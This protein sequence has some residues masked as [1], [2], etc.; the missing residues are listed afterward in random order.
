MA[1]TEEQ[2]KLLQGGADRAKEQGVGDD[3]A[4]K[5]REVLTRL[6][7]SRTRPVEEAGIGGAEATYNAVARGGL[8]LRS[9]P[10][11]EQAELQAK[12]ARAEE[13]RARRDE[14]GELPLWERILTARIGGREDP[15]ALRA[16]AAKQAGIAAEVQQRK[17]N[18]PMTEAGGAQLQNIMESTSLF[19]GIKRAASDPLATM[20]GV[21]QVGLEQA[22]TIAAA[23]A[24]RNPALGIAAFSASGYVQERF[25]QLVGEAAEAGYDLTNPAQARAAIE[26]TEFMQRQEQRGKTRGVIIAAVDAITA[27][28]ASK[29][30]VSWKG[31]AGNTGVQ[32]VGGGG[33]EAAAEYADT[34]T[35]NPG[36][37]L[38][39]A[40]AEG[41]T[42]P[43]D[44]AAFALR[45]GPSPSGTELDPEA[46][47]LEAKED[48]ALQA[49]ALAE[50]EA[51]KVQAEQVEGTVREARDAYA[52]S[53]IPQAEFAKGREKQRQ[54][55]VMDPQTELGTQFRT[56]RLAENRYLTDDKTAKAH[57]AEFFKTQMPKE[58]PAVVQEEWLAALDDYATNRIELEREVDPPATQAEMALDPAQPATEGQPAPEPE[59]DADGQMALPLDEAQAAPTIA[60]AQRVASMAA[61]RGVPIAP[62]ALDVI[63]TEIEQI[64]TLESAE[65]PAAL[66]ALVAKY[67]QGKAPAAKATVSTPAAAKPTANTA[68]AKQR[69][70]AIDTLGKDWEND[71]KFPGLAPKLDSGAV[72]KKDKSGKTGFERAVDAAKNE[73]MAAAEPQA[74]ET[75]VVEG[76]TPAVENAAPATTPPVADTTPMVLPEIKDKALSPGEK[77]VW[78]VL[79]DAFQNNGQDAVI[80][81]DGT[82]NTQKIAELAGLKSRQAVR[83]ALTRL[84]PKIAKASGLKPEQIKQR[85][86]E[87]RIQN[88]EEAVAPDAPVSVLDQAGLAEGAGFN[89]KASINQGARDGMDAA[90]A[91]YLDN[92]VSNA[93]NPVADQ[94]AAEARERVRTQDE[95]MLG[96]LE[97]GLRTAW[98]NRKSD[99]GTAYADLSLEDKI[100][101]MRS[102]QEWVYSTA[103]DKD[104]TLSDDQRNLERNTIPQVENLQDENLDANAVAAETAPQDDGADAGG[105]EANRSETDTVGAADAGPVAEAETD[106]TPEVAGAAKAP[107]VEVKKKKKI[108]N[109]KDVKPRFSVAEVEAEAAGTTATAIRAATKWLIGSEQ[110]GKIIVV[111]SPEDLIGLVLGRQVPISGTDMNDILAAENPYGFVLPD[112]NGVPYAYFFT[113]NMTPGN[114][115]AAVAHEIGS[116]I[117]MDNILNEAELTKANDQILEWAEKDDG[118]LESEIAKRAIARVENAK[119]KGGILGKTKAALDAAIR[120]ENI[121]YFIEESVLAG[122]NPTVDSKLPLVRFLHRIREAFK[123]ALAKFSGN[124]NQPLFASDFIDVARGAAQLQFIKSKANAEVSPKFGVSAPTTPAEKSWVKKNFGGPK[125]VQ[126]TTDLETVAKGGR[127]STKF[128]SRLVRDVTP[129]MPSVKVWYDAMLAAEKTYNTVRAMVEGI[130]VRARQLPLERR[131]VVNKFIG[132]ATFYQKWGY[133]P[134]LEGK[135]VK[136]DPIMKQKFDR[137]SAEE[138]QVVRDVFQHGADMQKMMNDIAKEL[139]V[140]GKLFQFHSKLDGPYAPLKRFGNYVA[141]LKSQELLDAEVK[142]KE[143]G[144]KASANAVEKLKGDGAH[145]VVSFFDTAGAAA[146][147]A[148]ENETKYASAE[149][150][151]RADNGNYGTAQDSQVYNK[152]MASLGTVG[153]PSDAKTAVEK[154]LKDLYFQSLD[155]RS[156]RLAGSRRLNRAGYEKDM[157]RSVL[158]HGRSQAR[159]ISQLKH[160]AEIN[161]ALVDAQKEAKAS[162]KDRKEL[163]PIFNLV[164]RKYSSVLTPNDGFGSKLVDYTLATNTALMLSTSAGYHVQ[165]ATQPLK[166]AGKIA[167]DFNTPKAWPEVIK[168]YAV[169]RAVISSS[170][171]RQV[172]TTF[173]AGIAPTNNT[174]IIDINKA[175]PHLRPLLQK[176]QD[177]GLMDVGIE[178]DLSLGDRFD[179]G[180]ET[181]N[182]FTE[183]GRNVFHRLMQIARYVEAHNRVSSAVAAFE[184]AKKD[185]RRLKMM[186]MTAEEYAISVI[187]DTHGVY[188]KLESPV[189]VDVLPRVT[190]QFKKYPLMIAW[191]YADAAKKAFAGDTKEQK[192]AGRRVLAIQLAQTG[193]LSGAV[194]IPMFTTVASWFLAAIG[195]EDEPVDFERYI[196]DMFPDNPDMAT[197]INRGVPAWFGLDMSIKLQESDIF[198]PFNPDY[199]KYD[200]RDGGAVAFVAKLGLGPTASTLNNVDNAIDFGQR[201]NV[202]RAIESVL[203]R[204]PRSMAE[205]Y[206]YSED[207]YTKRNGQVLADPRTF[208]A[209]DLFS[210]AMGLPS[211]KIN[212]I[213]FT[214]GQQYEL[215]QWVSKQTGRVTREYIKATEA[216]DQDRKNELREEFKALNDS[217][218]RLR[219]FFNGSPDEMKRQSVSK[220]RAA[221]RRHKTEE[222]KG[223]RALSINN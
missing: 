120:S 14:A 200:L 169:S 79:K 52:G 127:D 9:A 22:P 71:D 182:K 61:A 82:W 180:Y 152:V 65:R 204:G 15:E 94:R 110:K 153:L 199:T 155:E 75:P 49:Q 57:V 125:A 103:P 116:H 40:L 87:T 92:E 203:P 191:M 193:L 157:I 29:S 214:V 62:E 131:A 5:A 24:T 66:S 126:F 16:G 196:Q 132:D 170:F 101:W 33:G 156:A 98:D 154:M 105:A 34:G 186:D 54:A 13:D 111:R 108:I 184:I 151:V 63:A 223:Q 173:T 219:P 208:D 117:G 146:K 56:W 139:G 38:V 6:V 150:S 20:S 21:A 44:V 11:V 145:Y 195:D 168:G 177:R 31:L 135:T 72:Y 119:K 143:D 171:L 197:L 160:G 220:L 45:R 69:Q 178:E 130:A 109:P 3:P 118:S 122:V 121:A 211:T 85:L 83:T 123:V 77:K 74:T 136:I 99:G 190:T 221:V 78:D 80:Q 28:I 162:A 4:D 7:N 1:L 26:D 86:S 115:R 23:A 42:A 133:D 174:M 43:A 128:L 59:V 201:G 213:K 37:V 138:Q 35:F 147:F 183:G 50:E 84:K 27:G 124:S 76:Q 32:A 149:S 187:E 30:P 140:E 134:K 205:S 166:S 207:G 39:E 106:A 104:T 112:S 96:K 18:Y 167:G 53:F 212:Q 185:P 47:M 48:A 175:P 19:D 25:G 89:T 88:V 90:D 70:Y 102:V 8:N 161:Q 97:S 192:A 113:D 100:D 144:T 107:T 46:A 17:Q 91:A 64:K 188:S 10:N 158:S 206:R 73:M 114:E 209:W 198:M 55:D 12:A 163:Q 181:A 141:Q 129:K 210:N 137:L 217:R 164:S 95:A 222:R 68:K 176:M 189:I 58:D 165:N 36:E 216:G 194:G 51:V 60:P 81:P 218:D 93:P 159:L 172:A 2:L 41:V 148:A 67:T 202:Q 179:T 142:A 215:N